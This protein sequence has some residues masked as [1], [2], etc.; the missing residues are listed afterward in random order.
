MTSTL[1]CPTA[2]NLN[3]LPHI[4]HP[5]FKSRVLPTLKGKGHQPGKGIGQYTTGATDEGWGRVYVVVTPE[6]DCPT[7]LRR[8]RAR[9][10]TRP[11]AL[12]LPRLDEG[13]YPHLV[14]LAR[15]YSHEFVLR[16]AVGDDAGRAVC[17]IRPGK[18]AAPHWTHRRRDPRH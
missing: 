17:V 15:S 11:M 3:E 9:S 8:P 2:T 5:E 4:P 18:V 1:D 6:V 7:V 10:N 13:T 12:L 14:G 16:E